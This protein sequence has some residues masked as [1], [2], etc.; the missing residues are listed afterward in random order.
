MRD[1]AMY[2][3]S[4]QIEIIELERRIKSG[5]YSPFLEAQLKKKQAQLKR[6]DDL[7][8]A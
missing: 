4:L 2:E 7:K 5:E 3:A 8:G 1:S 6:L